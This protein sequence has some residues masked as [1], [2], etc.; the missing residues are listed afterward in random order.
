MSG[1]CS[2]LWSILQADMTYPSVNDLLI[3]VLHHVPSEMWGAPSHWK[4]I[5]NHVLCHSETHE[6][7]RCSAYGSHHLEFKIFVAP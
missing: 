2:G 3:L 4:Y 1:G 5:C 6:W 7:L